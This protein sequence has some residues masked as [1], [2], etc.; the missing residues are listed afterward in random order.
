MTTDTMT[1]EQADVYWAYRR[2]GYNDNRTA[3]G[4]VNLLGLQY[5]GP[6]GPSVANPARRGWRDGAIER[7]NE[8]NQPKPPRNWANEYPY[9][10]DSDGRWHGKRG[11]VITQPTPVEPLP[12]VDYWANWKAEFLATLK[13]RRPCV[14]ADYYDTGDGEMGLIDLCSDGFEIALLGD[15]CDA[16]FALVNKAGVPWTPE[17]I[18]RGLLLQTLRLNIGSY[19]GDRH[20]FH[21]MDP[22]RAA[23][24]IVARIWEYDAED[25]KYRKER[26]ERQARR[27]AA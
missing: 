26:A 22:E 1:R 24:K 10:F 6:G 20:Y 7:I 2:D 8:K 12:F 13:A 11:R 21:K 5:G 4:L 15:W 9:G 19:S 17:E 25:E 3:R 16:V 14:T 18:E 27:A 23:E